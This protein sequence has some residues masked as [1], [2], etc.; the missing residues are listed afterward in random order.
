MKFSLVAL[1]L[2]A[3]AA[4]NP[5]A[6]AIDPSK[7]D[8]CIINCAVQG[9][10]GVGCNSPLDTGCVCPKPD[11][12]TKTRDCIKGAC[13]DKEGDAEGLFGQLCA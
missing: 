8:P 13:P 9:A 7:V 1:T 5:V 3:L 10:S 12:K 2:A 4:A 6:R 11:F